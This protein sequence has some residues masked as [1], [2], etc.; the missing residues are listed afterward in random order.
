MQVCHSGLEIIMAQAVFD[1][2][3]GVSS[4]EHVDRTGVAKAVHG[5]DDLEALRR[6]G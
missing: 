3:G 1:I 5:I 6:Q 2:G 4:G